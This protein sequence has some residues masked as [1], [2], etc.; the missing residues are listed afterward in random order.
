MTPIFNLLCKFDRQR[1]FGL[2]SVFQLC[3]A[4]NQWSFRKTGTVG[5]LASQ[6]KIGVWVQ[7]PGGAF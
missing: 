5:T 7:A 3:F 4:L 1:G 2:Y 6:A